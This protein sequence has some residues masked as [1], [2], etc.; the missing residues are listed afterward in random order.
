M[1]KIDTEALAEWIGW[2]VKS[3]D[4]ILGPLVYIFCD[5]NR[6]IEV[7]RQFLNH[8]Y[9]TDIITFDYSRGRM[10]SGD[11]FISLDTVATN[12]ELVNASYDNELLRVIIHGVLHLCGINDKGPG[13]REI[14]EQNENEALAMLCCDDNN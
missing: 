9:Y 13:E 6:I 7:N 11:M 1:P 12:A 3:H 8:D 10:V 2:V 5:D 14:M 4:R